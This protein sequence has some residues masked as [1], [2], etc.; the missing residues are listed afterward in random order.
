MRSTFRAAATALV[1]SLMAGAVHA[2][3]A[4]SGSLKIAYVNTAAIMEAAPGRDSATAILTREGNTFQA[5]LQKMQDS[6]NGLAQK[7]QKSEVTMSAAAKKKAQDEM[8]ALNTELE[9]K[10]LQFQQQFQARTNEIMA[11][12]QDVVRKV[13]E[14]LRVEGGYAMI[15]DHT[16]GQTPIIAADKNLD[17]TD[18]VVSRL[19]ATSRPA[20]PTTAKPGAAP[21]PAGVTPKKP[22][23]Q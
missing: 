19:R 15:L 10:N 14:D 7:F 17:I 3:A 16:P 4:S 5:Q 2:Q 20:L 8:T 22:P 21:A 9:G 18:A 6:L 12:I 1:L 23:T 11:P 13:I